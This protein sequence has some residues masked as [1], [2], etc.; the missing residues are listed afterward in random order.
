MSDNGID[1]ETD[2]ERKREGPN[3]A[4]ACLAPDDPRKASDETPPN[5]RRFPKNR[6]PKP[7][8]VPS[9]TGSSLPLKSV[10]LA[11]F[12]GKELYRCGFE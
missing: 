11:Y 1:G 6:R 7:A 2:T 9:D 8:N 10:P 5:A 12:A 4:S 3:S